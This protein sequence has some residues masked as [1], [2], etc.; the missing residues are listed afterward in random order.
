MNDLDNVALNLGQV[1]SIVAALGE[2]DAPEVY[3]GEGSLKYSDYRRECANEI[4]ARLDRAVK[5][6]GI[7]GIA[8]AFDED[9]YRVLTEALVQAEEDDLVD[10]INYFAGGE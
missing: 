3:F 8:V 6:E 5:R 2:Y 10:H 7:V 4:R 9:E 1:H